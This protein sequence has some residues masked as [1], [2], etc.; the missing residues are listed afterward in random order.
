MR[1]LYL[2][3]VCLAELHFR[4]IEVVALVLQPLLSVPVSP[5]RTPTEGGTPPTLQCSGHGLG[6]RR[7]VVLHVRAGH[8][9]LAVRVGVAG[10]QGV[11]QDG[12]LVLDCLVLQRDPVVLVD[13]LP[14][15]N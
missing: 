14:S 9:A 15:G 5:V 12:G 13:G 8:A 6:V 4:N 3:V 2:S 1:S 7:L 11:E 10:R